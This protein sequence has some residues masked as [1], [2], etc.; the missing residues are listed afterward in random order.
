MSPRFSKK[1]LAL[2]IGKTTLYYERTYGFHDRTGYAQV[3]GK[4]EELNRLFG[5]YS[6]L[7]DLMGLFSL[8]WQHFWEG[9]K[10]KEV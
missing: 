6:Q 7:K 5:E 8:D 3:T 4:G 9:R 10:T 2:W 1:E